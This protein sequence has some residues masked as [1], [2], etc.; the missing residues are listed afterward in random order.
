[1][2]KLVTKLALSDHLKSAQDSYHLR[3]QK[4]RLESPGVMSAAHRFRPWFLGE[5]ALTL[6][7]LA[8]VA[9]VLF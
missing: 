8:D 2:L 7:A 5:K 1:M 6:S 3:G 4:V 9:N